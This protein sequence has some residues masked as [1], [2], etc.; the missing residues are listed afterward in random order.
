MYEHVLKV[1]DRFE[2]EMM[3]D[4]PNLHL[5]CDV[6]FLA[7]VFEKIRKSSLKSYGLCPSHYLSAP[8]LSYDVIFKMTKVELEVISDVDMYLFFEK[9]MRGGVSCISRRY[10]KANNKYLK[11]YNPRQESEHIIYLNTNNFYGYAMS[12]FFLTSRFEWIDRKK[13]DSN[14][15]SSNSLKGCFFKVNIEYPK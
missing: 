15:C 14:K 12:K 1:W 6:L 2:M 7:D 3:K 11:L 10:S 9:G 8:A 13:F 4:Y 5:K